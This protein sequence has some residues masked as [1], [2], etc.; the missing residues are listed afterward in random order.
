MLLG[1][2]EIFVV[3]FRKLI[4]PAHNKIW[5]VKSLMLHFFNASN[6]LERPE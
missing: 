5:F 6:C 1:Y 2:D 3:L 4:F